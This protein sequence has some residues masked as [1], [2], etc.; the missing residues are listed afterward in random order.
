MDLKTNNHAAD[1]TPFVIDNREFYRRLFNIALPIMVQHLMLALVAAGDALMLGQVAQEQMTAV[2]LASQIQFIQNMILAA[3]TMAG[4]ILGAQYW[5]KGDKKTIQNLFHLML[6][7]A[8]AVSILFFAACELVPGFLMSIFTN[9]KAIMEIGILY[10]RIA[11]FSY[12]ITGISQCYL[13]VMKVTDHVSPS[14]WIS[15]SAVIL[16]IVFNSIFIFGFLGA[17]RMEAEG[18][19][20]ATTMARVIELGLCLVISSQKDYIRPDIRRLLT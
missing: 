11:G 18:A 4:S 1:T 20:L 16:N 9:D 14:A 19:A 17:P 6:R 13:A 15:S 2:S 12:L 3:F 7:W 8:G 10:L 5:G